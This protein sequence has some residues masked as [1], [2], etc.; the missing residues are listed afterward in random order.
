MK[1]RICSFPS[2]SA[3]ASTT[4]IVTGYSWKDLAALTLTILSHKIRPL[5]LVMAFSLIVGHV[6]FYSGCPEHAPLGQFVQ[7]GIVA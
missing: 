4:W 1:V 5:G 6:V 2:I 3:I 7:M